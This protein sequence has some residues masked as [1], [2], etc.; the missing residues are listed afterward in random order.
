MRPSTLPLL[1]ALSAAGAFAQELSNSTVPMQC[2]AICAP[3]VKLADICSPSMA[4]GSSSMSMS[5]STTNSMS[6]TMSMPS[7]MS[8]PTTGSAMNMMT[9]ATAAPAAKGVVSGAGMMYEMAKGQDDS[10]K[11]DAGQKVK[12][13]MM[14]LGKRQMTMGSTMSTMSMTMSMGPGMTVTMDRAEQQCICQNK[15]FNVGKVLSLCASCVGMNMGSGNMMGMEEVNR[16]MDECSFTST[17]YAAA[18]TSV[19]AGLQVSATKPIV[20]MSGATRGIDVAT[21]VFGVGMVVT[22]I[23]LGM[24]LLIGM[25]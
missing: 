22:S 11:M 15:S 12:R 5:M 19:L 16:L 7:G 21:S 10:I 6:K 20:A 18:A 4:M 1:A 8:M 14:M 9:T 2:M 17:S 13:A 24:G 25:M 3:I 23:G